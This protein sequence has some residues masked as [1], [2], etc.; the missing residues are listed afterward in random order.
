MLR[1]AFALSVVLIGL[2]VLVGAAAP[3]AQSAEPA[4]LFERATRWSDFLASVTAR[5]D[6]WTTN[7]GRAAP[8][9]EMVERLKKVATGLR[10]LAVAE[11]ACSDS[12]STVPYIARLAE[13]AGVELRVIGKP[14]AQ[15]FLEGHRTP[16]GRTATPTIVLLRGAG[17]A[18]V[19]VERP[20]ALQRWHLAP[21]A[22]ALEPTD[23]LS[24]KMSWYDWDR[25][26]STVAEIVTL[27]EHAATRR[28][29]TAAAPEIR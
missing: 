2:N 17:V 12:V 27:A 20:S 26:D 23:R 21:E 8:A 15:A 7:A 24:R 13:L 18:G 3:A 22:Q 9:P 10:L 28:D 29:S 11:G 1:P 25:G 14:A 6:T 16:D 4:A 5:R 19:W